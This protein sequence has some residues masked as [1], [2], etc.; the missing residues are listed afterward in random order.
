MVQPSDLPQLLLAL[1]ASGLLCG[2]PSGP[3]ARALAPASSA[4]FCTCQSLIRSGGLL[5]SGLVAAGERPTF[6]SSCRCGA[7]GAGGVCL[8]GRGTAAGSSLVSEPGAQAMLLVAVLWAWQPASTSSAVQASG[9]LAWVAVV[10][11]AVALPLLTPAV[12]QAQAMAASQ[13]LEH[14]RQATWPASTV[15][16]CW[17]YCCLRS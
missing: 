12:F 7:V 2:G 9:S 5:F 15:G 11:L 3:M 1:A 17:A 14:W 10:H 16:N 6:S 13:R 4:W 8:L